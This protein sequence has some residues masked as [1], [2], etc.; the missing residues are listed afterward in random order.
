MMLN[1]DPNDRFVYPYLVRMIYIDFLAH[2]NVARLDFH[3][4][5]APVSVGI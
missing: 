1:C 3:N 5:Y 4:I 2:L